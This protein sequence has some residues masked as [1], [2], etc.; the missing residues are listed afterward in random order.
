MTL[1]NRTQ[2]SK[3][4][5][6]QLSNMGPL[7][8]EFLTLGL[9]IFHPWLVDHDRF[10]IGKRGWSSVADARSSWL[11]DV[12]LSSYISVL[13]VWNQPTSPP[14]KSGL[15]QLGRTFCSGYSVPFGIFWDAGQKFF[16]LQKQCCQVCQTYVSLPA[17]SIFHS[18]LWVQQRHD[19][20]LPS[21]LVWEV[22]SEHNLAWLYALS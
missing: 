20:M 14:K 4:E 13:S 18:L 12:H 7:K 10:D 19:T 22:Q 8:V 9:P 6:K 3:I 21:V 5:W 1:A 16:S 17:G 11:C 15:M 2:R